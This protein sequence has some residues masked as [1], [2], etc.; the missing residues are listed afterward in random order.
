MIFQKAA[1]AVIKEFMKAVS[2]ILMGFQKSP[3]TVSRFVKKIVKIS[4]FSI[5]LK[6]VVSAFLKAVL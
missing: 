4:V 3:K 6:W 1:S 2:T 5:P